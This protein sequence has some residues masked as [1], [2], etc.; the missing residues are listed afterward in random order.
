MPGF[1]GTGPGGMGPMT[2][3]GRGYCRSGR[4]GWAPY[5]GRGRGGYGYGYAGRRVGPGFV[6]S[7]Q[8]V[9]YLKSEAEA[10]KRTLEDMEARIRELTAK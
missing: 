9:D 6:N 2:G 8:E 7:E 10:L 1:D 4:P 5:P 3:G